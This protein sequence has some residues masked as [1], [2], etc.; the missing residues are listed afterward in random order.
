ML[1]P[2]VGGRDTHNEEDVFLI[3]KLETW[4]LKVS[5]DVK[6]IQGYGNKSSGASKSVELNEAY[7]P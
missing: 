7:I 4:L 1:Y 5:I 2:P 3:L 6:S